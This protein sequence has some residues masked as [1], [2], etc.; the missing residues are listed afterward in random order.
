MGDRKYGS[1][2]AFEDGIALRA[3]R[4]TFGHPTTKLPITVEAAADWDRA[5]F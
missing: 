4:L 1:K 3:V 5:S 2:R